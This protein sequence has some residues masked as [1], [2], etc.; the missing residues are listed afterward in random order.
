MTNAIKQA[1]SESGLSY[2]AIEQET[3]VQRSSIMR[4]MRDEQSLRLDLAD[5]LAVYFGLEV[6]RRKKG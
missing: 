1:I 3:G 4:F 5:R 2:C 6:T